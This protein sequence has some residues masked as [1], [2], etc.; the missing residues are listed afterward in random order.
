[1]ADISKNK[2][3]DAVTGPQ[4]SDFISVTAPAEGTDFHTVWRNPDGSITTNGF[5]MLAENSGFRGMGATFSTQEQLPVVT[6]TVPAPITTTTT[7]TTTE[8]QPEPVYGD[9]NCNGEI[10]IG[11]VVLLAR[12]IAQDA[13]A[14]VTPQGVQNADC[15]KDQVVDS[16]DI[17]VICRYLAHLTD[18][19]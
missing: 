19:L 11:D 4:D 8:P 13:S 9:V 12:Y 18:T 2:I 14:S 7:T 3:G 6:T 15:D 16:S 10:E 17:T 1:M 5:L